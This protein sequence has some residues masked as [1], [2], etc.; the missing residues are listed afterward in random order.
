MKKS[1]LAAFGVAAVLALTACARSP[2]E[3][4]T[5]LF[6]VMSLATQRN[7]TKRLSM[8]YLAAALAGAHATLQRGDHRVGRLLLAGPQYDLVAG[9]GRHLGDARPHDPRTHDAKTLDRHGARRYRPVT[10][11]PQCSATSGAR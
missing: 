1:R 3:K 4:M 6:A 8:S 10:R 2:V 11:R 5:G 7:G 9:L